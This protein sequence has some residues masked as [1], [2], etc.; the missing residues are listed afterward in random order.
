[1]KVERTDKASL[2]STLVAFTRGTFA[3]L[4]PRTITE[5]TA[6]LPESGLFN[7]LPS[8][9][10]RVL[11]PSYLSVAQR[12]AVMD[13]LFCEAQ[14]S[15]NP[16]MLSAFDLHGFRRLVRNEKDLGLYWTM[17]EIVYL[18]KHGAAKFQKH[19][20]L[21]TGR[22]IRSIS[23]V[24]HKAKSP[25]FEGKVDRKNSAAAN[26]Y[27]HWFYDSGYGKID[28]GKY[29]SSTRYSKRVNPVTA[30]PRRRA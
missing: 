14:I 27:P 24:E 10:T 9:A 19:F 1:M 15:S 13:C 6:D 20:V 8:V 3:C 16:R 7:P 2:V 21:D 29:P 28:G 26:G 11:R 12:Y 22:P 17:S 30:R 18:H 4:N 5:L 23:R 25:L